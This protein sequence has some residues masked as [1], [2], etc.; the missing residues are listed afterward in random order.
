MSDEILKRLDRI[1]ELLTPPEPA[2]QARL[3]LPERCEGIPW[4]WCALQ[5]EDARI[6]RATLGD[7]LAWG[8]KG[9]RIQYRST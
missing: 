9:C 2:P 3:A 7:P 1:I 8:C 5:S 4:T 6:N